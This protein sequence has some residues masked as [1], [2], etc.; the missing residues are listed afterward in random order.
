MVPAVDPPRHSSFGEGPRH[1]PSQIIG[2]YYPAWKV[3]RG[4]KPS[5]LRLHLLTHVYYAFAGVAKDGAI[6]VMNK[7]LGRKDLTDIRQ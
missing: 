7:S 2:D 5:E 1:R 4:R 6:F 3:Y